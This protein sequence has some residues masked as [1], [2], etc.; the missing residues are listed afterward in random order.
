MAKFLLVVFDGLRPE[1]V[2]ADLM[3]NLT[4]FRAGGLYCPG[5]RAAMPSE[6]AVSRAVPP[7]NVAMIRVWSVRFST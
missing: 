3:P 2:S 1:L 6:T 4:G 7:T 5:S